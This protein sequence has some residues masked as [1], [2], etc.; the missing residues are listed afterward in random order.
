MVLD[1][2]HEV[3]YRLAAQGAVVRARYALILTDCYRRREAIQDRESHRKRV[4]CGALADQTRVGGAHRGATA[5]AVGVALKVGEAAS[6]G[7]TTIYDGPHQ[8]KITSGFASNDWFLR[9]DDSGGQRQYPMTDEAA[10]S[11]M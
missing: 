11:S 3:H 7:T 2:L 4:A 6:D 9:D 8:P 5:R 1:R 10:A